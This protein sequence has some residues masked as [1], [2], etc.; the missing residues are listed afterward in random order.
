[1]KPLLEFLK[2]EG[3]YKDMLHV[4]ATRLDRVPI[5]DVWTWEVFVEHM[6]LVP[7]HDAFW[8]DR[9]LWW[10][11]LHFQLPEGVERI[12]CCQCVLSERVFGTALDTA[13]LDASDL[14]YLASLRASIPPQP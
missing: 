13:D 6:H 10:P 3:R 5:R 9:S 14:A 11:S 2:D 7:R 1:M 4:I 8:T 12:Y